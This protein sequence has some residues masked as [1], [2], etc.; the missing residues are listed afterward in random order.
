[1]CRL[2]TYPLIYIL[3][4]CIANKMIPDETAPLGVVW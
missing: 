1:M 2:L 3:E 4:A